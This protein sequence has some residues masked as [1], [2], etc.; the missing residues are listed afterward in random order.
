MLRVLATIKRSS[1]ASD[2]GSQMGDLQSWTGEILT[3]SQGYIVSPELSNSTRSD[4][5]VHVDE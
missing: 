1:F 4:G 3:A 5:R 2:M